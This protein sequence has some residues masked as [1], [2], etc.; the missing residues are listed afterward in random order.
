[1][2]GQDS[3]RPPEREELLRFSAKRPETRVAAVEPVEVSDPEPLEPSTIG[4][5]SNRIVVR[6]HCAP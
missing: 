2:E 1:V 6:I 4:R 5:P 3:K